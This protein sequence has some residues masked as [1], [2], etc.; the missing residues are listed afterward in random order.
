M[1]LRGVR[2]RWR[3]APELTGALARVVAS[4]RFI[5]GPEVEAFEAAAA[6]F[7]DVRY[8]VGVSSGTDALLVARFDE[9]IVMFDLAIALRAARE[10]LFGQ[11]HLA[12]LRRRDGNLG[13]KV[14]GHADI[15]GV[16]VGRFDQLAPIGLDALIAPLVGKRL[17]LISAARRDGLQI[18]QSLTTAF[19]TGR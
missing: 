2:R 9:N 8:A 12:S 7:L 16:D 13:V 17:D 11:H 6:R 10:G 1:S 15:D 3:L 18:E 14:V 5:L 19:S 4:S